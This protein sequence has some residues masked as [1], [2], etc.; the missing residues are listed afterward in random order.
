MMYQDLLDF[1]IVAMNGMDTHYSE[2]FV[3]GLCEVDVQV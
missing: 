1:E 3:L 2:V